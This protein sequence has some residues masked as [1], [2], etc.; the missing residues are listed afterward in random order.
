VKNQ[1][2][3]RPAF[4]AI[5]L[6]L[7]LF[8]VPGLGHS[9]PV[10]G[11]GAVAER[12]GQHDFDFIFGRWKIHTRTRSLGSNMWTD[13]NGIGAYQKIWDGR[14]IL[15]EFETDGKAGHIEGL[16]LQTY[17][18]QSHQWSL[19]WVDS[20][21]GILGV[22]LIGQLQRWPGRVLCSRQC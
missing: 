11:N 8:L 7:A 18:P 9:N 16:G 19:Y 2:R 5:G 20:S 4:R 14:A 21:D 3:F 1:R 22:P 17:N 10:N 12:D 15:N 13:Y 6:I